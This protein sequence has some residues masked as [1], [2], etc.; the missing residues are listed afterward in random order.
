[1]T[2][3]ADQLPAHLARSVGRVY[4]IAGAEPLLVQECR[5]QVIRAAQQEGFAE[6]TVHEVSQKFDWDLLAE[7]AAS[8]SLFSSRKIVDIRLPTGR[9][10]RDGS[11]ALIEMAEAADPDVLLLVSCGHW[12]TSL[13]KSKW[14]SVLARAGVL[15]EIWPIK[16]HELPRWI[17]GRM[18]A[19]GLKP[20]AGAIEMLADLVEGN[21]LAAQQEI[22]KLLLLEQGAKVTAED[23]TRAVANSSRFDAFRLVECALQGRLDECLRV[24]SGLKRTNVAIQAVSGALHRELTLADTVR[25][26]ARSGESESAVFGRLR[27]WPAR[28]GPIRRAVN[29]L[30]EYDFGESFRALTLIDRQSKGRAPGDP[31]QTLDRLLWHLCDPGAVSLD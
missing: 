30:S 26:A 7:D 12:D 3:K 16:P 17:K 28:Q 21:L 18:M 5:D 8:L 31:W 14:A 11:K 2:V 1:M 10:G 27:I 25:V 4:L 19:A 23:V 24:A 6:R 13:R 29:Q 9:P 20:E 15:V 22:D